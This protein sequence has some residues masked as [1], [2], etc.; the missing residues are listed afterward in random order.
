MSAFF[1]S[2]RGYQEG[3][4]SLELIE[5]KLRSGYFDAKDYIYNSMENQWIL[6]ANHPKTR[7]VCDE[8]RQHEDHTDP[9]GKGVP[10]HDWYLL[11]GQNQMG[12]YHFGQLVAMLQEQKA[13]E[14]DF[15]WSPAMVAWQKI[16]ECPYFT[17]EYLK[18]YWVQDMS[19]GQG[20]PH[21][22]RKSVRVE[23][24]SSLVVHNHRRLWNGRSFEVSS[25]GASLQ[26]ESA[27]SLLIGEVVIVHYRPSKKVPAFNVH[28]EVV[29][30]HPLARDPSPSSAQAYRVGVKFI[31]VNSLSKTIIKELVGKGA[32]AA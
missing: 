8:L 25:G 18:N 1:I 28:C 20:A 32:V 19:S 10:E 4:H 11:R 27:S 23:Y 3:P 29:A 2:R 17:P 30:V 15:V 6:L 9:N 14:Y 16:S 22:R 5:D 21:L 24:N 31:K 7:L 13:F 12:P 26:M